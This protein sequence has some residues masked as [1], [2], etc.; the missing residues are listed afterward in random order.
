MPESAETTAATVMVTPSLISVIF[1]VKPT[2]NTP[3]VGVTLVTNGR[4][5]VS[6]TVATWPL[7]RVTFGA[8]M[9]FVRVSPWA[10]RMKKNVSMSL[11]I[12]IP[13][14]MPASGLNPPNC[15]IPTSNDPWRKGTLRSCEKVFSV[16]MPT[17]VPLLGQ[18]PV[19]TR[20][21]GNGKGKNGVPAEVTPD[22]LVL[23]VPEV[24]VLLVPL[25]L[26][27]ARAS[28]SCCCPTC[29]CRA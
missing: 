16:S 2:A 14:V 24:L 19:F 26:S 17:I 8:N 5:T 29:C 3:T 22:V 28:C 13:T 10:A 21:S 27:R 18:F 25:V 11:K 23:L 9:M 7:N 12:A 4:L 6:C 1:G 20:L 15:G